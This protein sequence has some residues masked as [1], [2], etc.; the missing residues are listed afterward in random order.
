MPTT[1]GAA[2]A[3]NS[4]DPF[5]GPKRAFGA[6]LLTQGSTSA[7]IIGQ[8]LG[9]F[10]A[11]AAL[12]RLELATMVVHRLNGVL[13]W[14]TGPDA[15]DGSL[16]F[17][18]HAGGTAGSAPSTRLLQVRFFWETAIEIASVMDGAVVLAAPWARESG[19][20]PVASFSE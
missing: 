11:G 12:V 10:R 4:S 18:E 19:I 15:P 9:E 6:M 2:V 3:N 14:P 17:A 16:V 7:V 5:R 13:Q 8:D 20:F 1:Y